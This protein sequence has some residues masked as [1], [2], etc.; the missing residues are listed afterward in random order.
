[1][2]STWPMRKFSVGDQTPTLFHLLHWGFVLGVTQILVYAL[3]VTQILAFL[4]TN[5]LI[6]PMR[7][8]W[9]TKPM[10]GPNVNGFA[11]K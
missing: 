6:S 8:C 9:G 10:R 5:M 4:D 3:G 1:M 2:K 7:N 11:L